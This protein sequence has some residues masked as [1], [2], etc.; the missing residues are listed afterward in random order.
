MATTGRRGRDTDSASRRAAGR[1]TP[2]AGD[3][4]SPGSRSSRSAT[5][6]RGGRVA[7]WYGVARAG[8]GCCAWTGCPR[9]RAEKTMWSRP[10][11]RTAFDAEL[12]PGLLQQRPAVG[13]DGGTVGGDAER[14]VRRPNVSRSVRGSSLV[15]STVHPSGS[16]TSRSTSSA[17]VDVDRLRDGQPRADV[18][19]RAAA[20]R[21]RPRSRWPGRAARPPT[22]ETTSRA[23]VVPGRGRAPGAWGGSSGRGLCLG[24]CTTTSDLEGGGG[25]GRARGVVRLQPQPHQPDRQVR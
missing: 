4:R 14:T 3:H 8:T 23:A 18:H 25:E 19:G 1:R 24:S 16:A 11:P 5:T 2:P 12:Q 20:G 9:P 10:T 7:V 22:D 21:P 17:T 15:S 6:A 13:G